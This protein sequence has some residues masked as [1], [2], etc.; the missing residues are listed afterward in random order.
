LSKNIY[1][2]GK[3]FKCEFCLIVPVPVH[4]LRI[5]YGLSI[6]P[7]KTHKKILIWFKCYLLSEQATSSLHRLSRSL[8]REPAVPLGP[9]P[10]AHSP[11]SPPRSGG[12][13]SRSPYAW[14]R[15][16]NE[17]YTYATATHRLR[18]SLKQYEDEREH[19][20]DS[21]LYLSPRVSI[22]LL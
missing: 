12:R 16:E 21:R 3:Y 15:E 9:R 19:Q 20:H 11:G 8:E 5:A 10:R 18:A 22:G 14:N 6:A 17:D 1:I 4:V 2:N 7:D 13:R